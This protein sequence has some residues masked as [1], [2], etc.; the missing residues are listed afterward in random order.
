MRQRREIVGFPDEAPSETGHGA[1]DFDIQLSAFEAS[2][3][4]FSLG[5]GRRS[6]G[7][8]TSR[9]AWRLL[10][11]TCEDTSISNPGLI[12]NKEAADCLRYVDVAKRPEVAVAL[13][14]LQQFRRPRQRWI[15]LWAV[16]AMLFNQIALAE[17]FCRVAPSSHETHTFRI[18]DAGATPVRCHGSSGD[19]AKVLPD[20]GQIGCTAHC[21]DADKQ[22]R[23]IASPTFPAM[24][25]AD[26]EVA[27]LRHD[28]SAGLIASDPRSADAVRDRHGSIYRV[29]LI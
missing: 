9:R 17:H 25:G 29:L 15:A 3:S 16:M 8:S 2:C 24:I 14:A 19:T 20:L 10:R 18:S 22:V 23:D 21:N 12:Q 5:S 6:A 4:S 27:L 1:T 26:P 28:R 7:S 13:R 11:G